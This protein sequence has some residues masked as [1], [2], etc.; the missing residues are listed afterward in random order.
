MHDYWT[1]RNALAKSF[2]PRTQIL[3]DRD[4]SPARENADVKEKGRKKG[5]AQFNILANRFERKELRFKTDV[6]KN[7]IEVSV[8][9]SS[10]PLPI[11]VD[12]YDNL[13][14]PFG[15]KYCFSNRYRASLYTSFYD[16]AREIGIR[17]CSP[18][19][20]IPKMEKYL[21]ASERSIIGASPITKA[22]SIKVPLKIGARFENVLPIERER[23]VT[24]RMLQFLT[25]SKYPY[26]L[27]TKSTVISE[28]AYIKAMSGFEN[29]VRVQITMISSDENLIKRL[30]PNAPTIKERMKACKRLIKAG[31]PVIARI[32]PFSIFINDNKDKVDEYIG[33]LKDNGITDVCIDNFSYGI[34]TDKMRNDYY[35]MGIDFDKM[36]E[37]SSNYQRISSYLL[38]LFMRYFRKHGINISSYDFGQAMENSHEYIC[39]GI[40]DK[41]PWDKFNFGNVNTALRFIQRAE[42]PVSWSDFDS[43]VQRKGGFLSENIR[44]DVRNMWNAGL[45]HNKDRN[46]AIDFGA[47]IL[48][49]GADDDGIIWK[50]SQDTDLRKGIINYILEKI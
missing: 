4:L 41:A 1:V 3:F 29:G 12:L 31:I 33:M 28:D 40:T 19:Y 9:A 25:E 22:L 16:N 47:H 36:L 23:K 38:T 42:R 49:V 39:C 35:A 24:L 50:Y 21:S 14:C 10:C 8:R 15:C 45:Y 2:F 34:Q 18:D 37:A 43:F 5:Y 6:I 20:F 7:F 17:S 27:N 44:S 11:N 32:E 46:L 30:E 26:I 48:A 13:I